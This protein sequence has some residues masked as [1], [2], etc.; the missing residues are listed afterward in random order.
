VRKRVFYVS[1]NLTWGAVQTAPGYYQ[2]TYCTSPYLVTATSLSGPNLPTPNSM[3]HSHN[4]PSN[5][6]IATPGYE[7]SPSHNLPSTTTAPHL[8]LRSGP[9]KMTPPRELHYG[10]PIR[11]AGL[12]LKISPA[13]RVWSPVKSS[14]SCTKGS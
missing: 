4:M 9:S 13:T 8:N 10:H 5:Y 11:K 1:N 12:F 6:H 14:A 2:Y 7:I 3:S